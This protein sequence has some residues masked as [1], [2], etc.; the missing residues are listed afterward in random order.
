MAER[1]FL[2]VV[3]KGYDPRDF[4]LISGGG[5]GP[6]H[7]AAIAKRL[8]IERVY[9]PK[10]AAVFSALG[11]MVAD[12]GYVLTRFLYR[13][14]DQVD[15]ARVQDLY[16]SME[17]E[18]SKVFADQGIDLADMLMVR[19][20]EMRYY[21]QLRD[22]S[23]NLP[24]VPLNAPFTPTTL[25]QLIATFHERHEAMF[26]WGDPSLPVVL[27]LLKLRAVVKR[28]PLAFKKEGPHGSDPTTALKRRRRTYFRDAG[29]FV[30]ETPCYDGAKVVPGNV[31]A[32]PAII[33]EATTT[34][35][36]PPGCSIEVDSY[37]NYLLTV[38]ADKK[39]TSAGQ[40]GR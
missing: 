32:G 27:G 12:Y 22:L 8:G 11:G 29:G 9:I 26:G 23:I 15:L 14:D 37:G 34:V 4:V 38:P 2:S 33:E 24:E 1:V 20:A 17:A 30:D 3:E 36:I 40:E 13:R 16:S 28:Q 10:H 39:T 35:V 5:A 6:V 19:G 25:D 18:G 7:A 21:G 31:I